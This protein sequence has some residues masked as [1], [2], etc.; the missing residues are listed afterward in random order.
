VARRVDAR[1][2]FGLYDH[3]LELAGLVNHPLNRDLLLEDLLLRF[4]RLGGRS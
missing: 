2:L 1:G 4:D 3:L